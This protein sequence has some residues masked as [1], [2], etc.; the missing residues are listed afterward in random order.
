MNSREAHASREIL[1]GSS[2][3]AQRRPPLASQN[4]FRMPVRTNQAAA[5]AK[6]K[7]PKIINPLSDGRQPL[8]RRRRPMRR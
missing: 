5:A 8:L 7:M 4:I 1:A 6:I 3:R 2:P